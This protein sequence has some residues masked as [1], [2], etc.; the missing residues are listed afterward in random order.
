MVL[1][2]MANIQTSHQCHH[3]GV[4]AWQDS[5]YNNQHSTGGECYSG[6]GDGEAQ[7]FQPL[8]T[9]LAE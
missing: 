1:L 5:E 7:L 3:S 4:L 8:Q 2:H 9:S 6:G